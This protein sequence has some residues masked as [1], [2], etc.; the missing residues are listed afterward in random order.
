MKTKLLKLPQSSVLLTHK[1][2]RILFDPGSFSMPSQEIQNIDILIITHAHGDH[3]NEENINYVIEHSSSSQI[4]T[5]SQVASKLKAIDIEAQVVEGSQITHI[6]DI[7]IQAHDNTHEEIYGEF[8]Q[9]Q[10]TGYY[11]DAVFFHPDDAFTKPVKPIKAISTVIIAP[12]MRVKMAIDYIKENP[13][14]VHI[15]VHEK[16]ASATFA[17][18][19]QNIIKA[20]IPDS[21]TYVHPESD[22]VEVLL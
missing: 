4:I 19:L 7:E 14:S 20:N 8:G 10:N 18:W 3:Y 11:I 17:S 6:D 22:A 16:V 15:G 5:N 9:V 1:G 2:K 21:I 12:F 13:K